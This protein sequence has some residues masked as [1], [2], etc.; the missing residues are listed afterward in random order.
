MVYFLLF[1]AIIAEVIAT[2]SLK[3][4]EQFTRLIPS[5]I[6][7]IG[8]GT[9]FYL[10]T[11]VLKTMQVGIAYAIWTSVGIVIVSVIGMILFKQT[12]DLPAIIGIMLITAGVISIT[13][14]SKTTAGH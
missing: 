3:Y 10:L 13:L 9:A 8:Y 2:T 5:V 7:V 4:S 11:I 14:F 1:I 6:V 12:P